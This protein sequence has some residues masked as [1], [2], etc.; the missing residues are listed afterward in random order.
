M[1]HP[2]FASIRASP[3]ILQNA[4]WSILRISLSHLVCKPGDPP[5]TSIQGDKIRKKQK[6][7]E[8]HWHLGSRRG[9]WSLSFVV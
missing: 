4:G 5:M 8:S 6:Q 2:K 7:D 1:I 9:I 3:P